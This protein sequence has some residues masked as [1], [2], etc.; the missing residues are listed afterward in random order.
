MA[1]IIGTAWKNSK[2]FPL[3]VAG[4]GIKIDKLEDRLRHF[5]RGTVQLLLD[6]QAASVA[7][8]TDK[9]SFWT[10]SCGE[11]ISSEIGRWMRS[12][13]LIPWP[14]ASPPKFV[15]R[16]VAPGTFEVRQTRGV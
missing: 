9:K 8:N 15:L 6:G 1:E 3:G 13:G 2:G 5:P 14:D 12:R 16:A 10:Q 11:L 4:Y 7:A